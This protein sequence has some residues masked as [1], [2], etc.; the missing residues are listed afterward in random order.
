VCGF[1]LHA[2]GCWLN[3][4]WRAADAEGKGKP[5]W[6]L[7]RNAQLNAP[8]PPAPYQMGCLV[9]VLYDDDVWCAALFQCYVCSGKLCSCGILHY[10]CAYFPTLGPFKIVS[11][12]MPSSKTNDKSY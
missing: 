10:R 9:E 12:I 8:A 6:G 4:V 11:A 2:C 7:V 3:S 1:P 5:Q